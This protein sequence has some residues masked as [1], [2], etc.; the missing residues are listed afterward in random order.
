MLNFEKMG[1]GDYYRILKVDCSATDEELKKAYKRLAMKWHP[2]KN[3]QQNSAQKEKA[4]A[5]FKQISEAYDVLSDPKKRQIYDFYGQYPLKS[6]GNYANADSGNYQMEKKGGV[7]ESKLACSLEDLYKGCKKK[8]R[9]SRAV[10][11]EF[12]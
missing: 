7:V 6:K 11:D 1:A 9:I 10:L 3:L 2:D 8:M 5:K 12:G 4:E